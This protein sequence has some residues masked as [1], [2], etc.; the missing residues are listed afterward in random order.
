MFPELLEN[1]LSLFVMQ[2]E[3]VLG[4]D[5]HVIHVDFEPFFCDHVCTDVVHKH[6]KGG[7]CI[8]K[9]EEHD[10]WFVE[11]KGGDECCFPLVFLPKPNV[12]IPTSDVELG[13]EGR[14]QIGRA[15]V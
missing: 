15:H 3:I 8:G 5:A 10:C 11:S 6:L 12:V 4:V 1:S 2:G 7:R 14:V 9:S 13:E